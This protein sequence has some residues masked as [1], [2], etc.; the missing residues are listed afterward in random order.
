MITTVTLN[1]AVDKTYTISNLVM[2]QVNRVGTVHNYAGGKGINVSKILQQFQVESTAAGFLGGYTG[3]FIE[4]SL[5]REGISCHFTRIQGE[6]RSNSNILGEDGYVTEILEP[7][8][9]IQKEE[10]ERFLHDYGIICRDSRLVILSGSIAGGL[11]PAIYQT[12]IQMGKEA[13]CKVFLDTSK[14]ALTEGIAALPY[15]VKPNLKELEFVVKHKLDHVELIA[16]AAEMLC[17]RGIAKV[18]VSLG[19]KGLLYADENGV[20]RAVPPKI[21][22][23]STVGCGDSVV[24]SF[25]MSELQGASAEAAVRDAAAIAAAAAMTEENGKLL[26]DE[27]ETLQ[28]QIRIDH[29]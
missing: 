19:Q 11:S 16:E 5:L 8:P 14:E 29:L 27:I 13:G 23:R 21:K 4:D 22:V 7:G 12:L 9:I 24:A 18:A 26:K 28:K 1:P 6:T 17:K 2:G 25:A 20:L 15:F 10:Q 3:Q